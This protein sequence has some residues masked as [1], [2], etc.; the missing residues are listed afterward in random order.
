MS[1][2]KSSVQ[3]KKEE[4]K[5]NIRNMAQ[6]VDDIID[7]IYKSIDDEMVIHSTNGRRMP[8]EKEFLGRIRNDIRVNSR[9]R[10]IKYI[11]VFIIVY[12][13]MLGAYFGSVNK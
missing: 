13:G 9:K 2:D 11:F 12:V 7:I 8:N 10:I 6:L 3:I 5:D 4:I 1:P